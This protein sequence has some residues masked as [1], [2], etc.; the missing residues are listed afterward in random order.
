MRLLIISNFYPPN[1][2]GGYEMWCQE[3]A[4]TLEE[5]GHQVL[6]LTSRNDRRRF[7]PTE[8]GLI[9]RALYFEMDFISL[10]N[11]ALFFTSRQ[12]RER[13]NILTLRSVVEQYRPDLIY[14]WG[15]WNLPRSLAAQAENLFPDRVVYYIADYWPSLPNQ[16]EFY[17][18]EQ[19]RSLP[20]KLVRKL[21]K[22]SVKRILAQ[23]AIPSLEFPHAQFPSRYLKEELISRDIAFKDTRIIYGAIDIDLFT[24]N[25]FKSI[26]PKD[27][28]LALLYLGRLVEEKG[29][30]TAIEALDI[31]INGSGHKNVE[32][33]IA[34]SGSADYKTRLESL[35]RELAVDQYVK[36]IG[37]YPQAA[38]PELFAKNDVLLF[39][40]IWS[41]PFGRVLVEAMVCG[42]SVVGT[43][44]GG[45]SEVLIDH[46]NGL[47]YPPGDAEALAGR[48]L[49][50]KDNPELKRKM[51]RNGRKMAREHF[52]IHR[53]VNEIEDHL[54]TVLA[55]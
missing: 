54:M 37:A 49:Y 31:L 1:T 20:T 15:M 29:V 8:A 2:R 33:T 21:L 51:V 14:I 46:E 30:H 22:P 13:A 25:D 39:T 17:W 23:H 52:N 3:V 11:A 44:T 38:L 34:G 48:L 10:W 45:A 32:L 43:A 18:E 26:I 53:M 5:K 50:L 36:F 55:A 28:K 4:H 27:G 41:E 42:L 19:G 35:A 40:S 7:D 12:K 24:S 9:Q 47:I 6:V 16:Y